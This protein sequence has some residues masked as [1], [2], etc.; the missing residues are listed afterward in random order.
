MTSS[1]RRAKEAIDRK[2]AARDMY[3]NV[4]HPPPSSSGQVGGTQQGSTDGGGTNPA[5][6]AVL[7]PR[8]NV[9]QQGDEQ[10]LPNRSSN[11]AQIQAKEYTQALADASL[12]LYQAN[13]IGPI[14][15]SRELAAETLELNIDRRIAKLERI[16]NRFTEVSR[17]EVEA[18]SEIIR[19][20]RDIDDE[21]TYVIR[22]Q[23]RSREHEHRRS[24]PPPTRRRRRSA[25]PR[26]R[27]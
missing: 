26:A 2:K 24:E 22:E 19:D 9:S 21:A 6:S 10:D 17:D 7:T 14:N 4:T 15:R 1:Q 27:C 3:M 16:M 12:L 5:G 25:V 18:L 11:E 8:R 20:L 23:R 13:R